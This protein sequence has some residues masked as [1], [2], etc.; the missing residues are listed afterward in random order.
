MAKK[1]MSGHWMARQNRLAGAV[2]P[3]IAAGQIIAALAGAA[4]GATGKRGRGLTSQ[5]PLSINGPSAC[6]LCCQTKRR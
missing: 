2:G 4:A 1:A 3:F 6:P 5:S